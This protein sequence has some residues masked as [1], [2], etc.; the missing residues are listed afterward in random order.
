MAAG[1]GRSSI[2]AHPGVFAPPPRASL[3]HDLPVIGGPTVARAAPE[4]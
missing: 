4:V 3:R 1:A 2:L